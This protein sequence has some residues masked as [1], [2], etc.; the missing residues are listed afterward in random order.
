MMVGNWPYR[1]PTSLNRARPEAAWR[2]QEHIASEFAVSIMPSS[3]DGLLQSLSEYQLTF[4]R[5]LPAFL[6]GH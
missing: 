2:H 4:L 6:L 5:F 1:P 3:A